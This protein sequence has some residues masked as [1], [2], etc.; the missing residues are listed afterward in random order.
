MKNGQVP[1]AQM[2][3]L[4]AGKT[5]YVATTGSDSNP[6]TQEAPFRTIQ[7]AINSLPKY[8]SKEIAAINVA[9]GTYDEDISVLS[10]HSGGLDYGLKIEGNPSNPS[11]VKVRRVDVRSCSAVVA[12]HNLSI[13]GTRAPV[14]NIGNSNVLTS[15]V[16]I[17]PDGDM[18]Y[19]YSTYT[20]VLGRFACLYTSN[21]IVS[22]NATWN[23]VSISNSV[24][25]ASSI[26]IKNCSTGLEVGD[27]SNISP[28]MVLFYNQPKFVSNTL[29]A[30]KVG[31]GSIISGWEGQ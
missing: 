21:F 19:H 6:G 18:E 28:G 11:A 15:N 3:H 8:L 13:V 20:T 7:A 5:V 2:P 10:F 16:T 30:S 4:T 22:A 9:D 25:Y 12:L 29:N 14:F 17:Q 23:G 31:A 27:S 1:Y 24:L 26:S